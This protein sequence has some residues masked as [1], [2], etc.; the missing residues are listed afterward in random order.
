VPAADVDPFAVCGG[1]QFSLAGFRS[2]RNDS[3]TTSKS[4]SST[5]HLFLSRSSASGRVEEAV[6][7]SHANAGGDRERLPSFPKTPHDTRFFRG[8]SISAIDAA[9]A[10]NFP[11][12]TS[13]KKNAEAAVTQP[14]SIAQSEPRFCG[15]CEPQRARGP[16]NRQNHHGHVIWRGFRKW[17]EGTLR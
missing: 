16:Y 13:M 2:F 14:A 17:Q 8:E 6:D 7:L 9:W 4:L 11:I 15:G 10:K 5:F 3:K 12:R 1:G